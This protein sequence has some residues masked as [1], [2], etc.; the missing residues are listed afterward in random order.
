MKPIPTRSLPHFVALAGLAV[1]LVFLFCLRSPVRARAQAAST[2]VPTSPLNRLPSG[3]L[4]AFDQ[5]ALTMPRADLAK[6]AIQ[7]P[8]DLESLLAQLKSAEELDVERKAA[9]AILHPLTPE[10]Y[11]AKGSTPAQAA[12]IDKAEMQILHPDEY[13]AK[14]AR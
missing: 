11:R 14:F 1:L 10:Q 5:L 6:I 4:R 2:D 7:H 12:A 8:A 9:D 13:Q 3:A